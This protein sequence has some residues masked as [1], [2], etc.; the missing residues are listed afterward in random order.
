MR[1]LKT[2]ESEK[3]QRF[4]ELVQ[5]QAE[6]QNGVW[7]GFAGEGNEFETDQM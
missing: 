2:Q 6:K 3:F 4:H 5:R 1:G 7:F